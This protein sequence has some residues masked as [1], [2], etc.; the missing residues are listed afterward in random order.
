MYIH[1]DSLYN[2]CSHESTI[3][4]DVPAKQLVEQDT[5]QT[6]TNKII[7][8][9]DTLVLHLAASVSFILCMATNLVTIATHLTS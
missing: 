4:V 7:V 6:T 2:T 5:T 3:I 8:A 1:D 9:V